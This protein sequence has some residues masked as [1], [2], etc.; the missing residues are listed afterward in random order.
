MYQLHKT[1][2]YSESEKV[3]VYHIKTPSSLNSEKVIVYQLH[4]DTR[5]V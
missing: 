5:L 4:K 3:I 2:D 1:P